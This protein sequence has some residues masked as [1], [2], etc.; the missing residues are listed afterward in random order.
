M[1]IK[2]A[3]DLAIGVVGRTSPYPKVDI[4]TS[5]KY[6]YLL[7]FDSDGITSDAAPEKLKAS[8]LMF[9]TSATSNVNMMPNSKY[10]LIDSKITFGLISFD[11][12]IIIMKLATIIQKKR[13]ARDLEITPRIGRVSFEE[14]H[15]SIIKTAVVI[16]N[17]FLNFSM[18]RVAEKY[19]I[20]KNTSKRKS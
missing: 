2:V 1:L 18:V 13:I 10:P 3:S 11:L 15:S 16:M 19:M 4:V 17:C 8:G 9:I 12:E 7:K 5:V 6:I 14:I 20:V